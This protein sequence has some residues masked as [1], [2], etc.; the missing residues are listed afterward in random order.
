MAEAARGLYGRYVAWYSK[1]APALYLF[2]AVALVVCGVATWQATLANG[3]QDREADEIQ[4]RAF[5]CIDDRDA[6]AAE[7]SQ[8]LRDVTQARD[9]LSQKRGWATLRKESALVSWT[10]VLL[11]AP[12]DGS[13]APGLLRNFVNATAEL[14][15]SATHLKDVERQLIEANRD[16]KRARL[17]NPV[18]PPASEVCASGVFV[19]PAKP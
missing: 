16:L 14:N 3:R 19:P 1:W 15:A 11:S 12:L 13:A 9:T 18:V 2:V 4:A 17:Q 7:S 5:A 6:F 10:S 8:T